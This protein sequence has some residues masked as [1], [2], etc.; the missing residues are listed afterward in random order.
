VA[1]VVRVLVA[2][3][4]RTYREAIARA[5][6]YSHPQAAVNV[7]DPEEL[8]SEMDR[9]EPHVVICSQSTQQVRDGAL[10]WV[11]MLIVGEE[12]RAVVSVRGLPSTIV[13]NIQLAELGALIDRAEVLSKA[14]QQ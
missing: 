6:H 10:C 5:L 12:L 3:E 1:K 7:S 9:L 8:D 13:P 4:W 14:D 11:K 2:L